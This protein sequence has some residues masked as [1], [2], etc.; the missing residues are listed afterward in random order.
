MNSSHHKVSPNIVVLNINLSTLMSASLC[1][2][3]RVPPGCVQHQ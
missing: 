1:V 3:V 2:C